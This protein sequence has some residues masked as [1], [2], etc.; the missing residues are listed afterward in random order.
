VPRFFVYNYPNACSALE[1]IVIPDKITCIGDG[2]FSRCIGLA[3]ITIPGC[4]GLKN[5]T[6]PDGIKYLGN[7]I[8][9]DCGIGFEDERLYKE[10]VDEDDFDDYYYL[11]W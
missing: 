9:K 4:T 3:S 6:I 10:K 1:S 8:F 5:V 2:T 11:F 7:A